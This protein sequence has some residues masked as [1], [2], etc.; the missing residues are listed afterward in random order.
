MELKFL[1]FSLLLVTLYSFSCS[2]RTDIRYDDKRQNTSSEES[3][4][5][6]S[7]LEDIEEVFDNMNYESVISR[8]SPAVGAGFSITKF[9]YFVVFSNLDEDL[10]YR[11]IDNDVCHA[12]L[13]MTNHFVANLPD[14]VTPIF[15]FGDFDS[16]RNFSISNFK[17][18]EDDLSP[19]GF[20]KISKNAIVIRY[21]SWKGSIAHEITH[22]FIQHDFPGIP[23]WFNEG[24]A[25]LHEKSTYKNGELVGDFS[26]RI[27]SLRRAFRESSYTGLKTL[28]QTNDKELYG[29]KSPFYYAQ[30]RFLFMYLQEKGLL[31]EY[32]LSFRDSFERDETGIKQLENVSGKKLSELDEELKEYIQSFKQEWR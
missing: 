26:W 25:S 9:Q 14:S 32:Y 2:Q 27:L 12:S 20:Y 16:Y 31:Y 10:T 30:A 11:L 17:I 3:R 5:V 13:A 6:K 22:V 8:Y 24:L 28:M 1:T 4:K 18:D 19:F 15:L 7:P 21:V 23:S 29:K